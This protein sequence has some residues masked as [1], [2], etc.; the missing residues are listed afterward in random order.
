MSV[1]ETKDR[2]DVQVQVQMNALSNNLSKL[3]EAL[4]GLKGRLVIVLR[5]DEAAN[6]D[7]KIE[8]PLVPLAVSIRNFNYRVDTMTFE[9]VGMLE[10][11][12]L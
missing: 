1:E 11:L 3:E 10:R 12:E 8:G 4:A 5:E 6:E 7:S 2:E 9:V